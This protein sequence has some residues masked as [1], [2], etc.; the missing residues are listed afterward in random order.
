MNCKNLRIR[1]K[2]YKK[3]FYCVANKCVVDASSC[4][5]C[6]MKEYKTTTPIKRTAID[7]KTH[8]VSER[9]KACDISQSTK[10]IVWER[11]NHKCVFCGKE[12]P[13]TC[14]NSH[15]VKRSHGG[16]GIPENVVCACP[17][18]HHEYDNG[19]YSLN[20][21]VKAQNHMLKI[22]GPDWLLKPLR[23]NKWKELKNG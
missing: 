10:Q 22:Y 6:K 3:Y 7:K 1:S 4:Y 21:V 18:C 14:A 9:A 19:K 2:N 20:Y 13:I 23:Y 12:V 5:C 17:E 8:K 16:L 15:I 11:D